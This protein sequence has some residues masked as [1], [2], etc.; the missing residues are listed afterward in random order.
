M[1]IYE[2]SNSRL[3]ND[4]NRFPNDP[5]RRKRIR[6]MKKDMERLLAR[7]AGKPVPE[8]PSLEYVSPGKDEIKIDD[9]GQSQEPGK[10]RFF[11]K[12]PFILLVTGLLVVVLGGGGYFWYL[13]KKN[14]EPAKPPTTEEPPSEEVPPRQ[15][16]PEPTPLFPVDETDVLTLTET[17]DFLSQSQDIL[18]Q[19]YPPDSLR[20]IL[21][22]IKD[23]N[24]FLTLGEILDTLDLSIPPV[25]LAQLEDSYVVAFH[26]SYS[27]V[28]SP[29][30]AAKFK[31]ERS[32]SSL[33]EEFRMWE[34]S[35]EKDLTMLLLLTGRKGEPAS[36]QFL[37][38]TYKGV[39]IRYLN[40][41]D[42]TISLDYALIPEKDLVVITTSR[43]S[44]YMVINKVF[45]T[46]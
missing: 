27:G 16:T 28:N 31:P 33:R 7:A 43:E 45:V 37:D 2:A 18:R 32:Y 9:T 10:P 20:R 1:P 25:I 8:E 41:S 22:I 40:F 11:L 36:G 4:P 19:S 12:I 34:P 23:K 46:P 24:A 14:G 3:P 29:I 21:G 35:L 44:M 13:Q 17:Q 39:F 6:T 15:L 30:F 42:P 5:E 26:A 38:N